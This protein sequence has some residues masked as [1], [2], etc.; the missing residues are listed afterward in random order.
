VTQESPDD[1]HQVSLHA[2]AQDTLHPSQEIAQLTP[3]IAIAHKPES[4]IARR[5]AD[6]A[7]A[8]A[9]NRLLDQFRLR[10]PALT[11]Y[12]SVLSAGASGQT[13]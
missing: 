11:R 10:S 13:H 2:E 8:D 1:G 12:G 4:E 6:R 3:R 7:A 5:R 9:P